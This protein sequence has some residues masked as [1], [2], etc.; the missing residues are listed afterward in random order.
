MNWLAATLEA[1]ESGNTQ[2]IRQISALFLIAGQGA[3]KGTSDNI[4]NTD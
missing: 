4:M 3:D 1:I 2:K